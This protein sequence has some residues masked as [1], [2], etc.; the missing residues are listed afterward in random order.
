M[1]RCYRKKGTAS[2]YLDIRNPR[3]LAMSVKF[4]IARKEINCFLDAGGLDVVME[5]LTNDSK[6]RSPHIW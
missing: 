3:I 4:R 1:T 2:R 6:V 5:D